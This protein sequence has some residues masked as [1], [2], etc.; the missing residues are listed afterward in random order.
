MERS[1]ANEWGLYGLGGNVWEDCAS[2]ASGGSFGAWRGAA[3]YFIF[4]VYLR[5]ACRL[6]LDGFAPIRGSNYGFRLVLSR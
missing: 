6:G 1:G 4:P 2:D 5:C 3:W